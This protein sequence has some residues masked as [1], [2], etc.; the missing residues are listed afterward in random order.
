MFELTAPV[1]MSYIRAPR[2][3][4]STARLCPLLIRISGALQRRQETPPTSEPTEGAADEQSDNKA[5]QRDLHVLDGTA[6]GVCD[7]A[8]VDRLLAQAKVRQLYVS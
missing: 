6:E 4:Q 7:R 5:R 8:V 2:L 1:S 3:H